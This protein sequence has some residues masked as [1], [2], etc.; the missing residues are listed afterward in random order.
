VAHSPEPSEGATAASKKARQEALESLSTEPPAG[1]TV[2]RQTHQ[3]ALGKVGKLLKPHLKDG[4]DAEDV[5]RAAVLAYLEEWAQL[6]YRGSREAVVATE[7]VILQIRQDTVQQMTV[8]L[9]T[10]DG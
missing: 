10:I 1:P 9:G 5:L 2:M 7:R 3:H 8:E 4:Q 6:Y